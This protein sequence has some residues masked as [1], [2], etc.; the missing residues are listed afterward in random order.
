MI[1]RAIFLCIVSTKNVIM[2]KNVVARI[3]VFDKKNISLS[4]AFLQKV[5]PMRG[6]PPDT[7]RFFKTLLKMPGSYSS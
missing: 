6:F 1:E 5:Y 7:L 3:G 4:F 2:V